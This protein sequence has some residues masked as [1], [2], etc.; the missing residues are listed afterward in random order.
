M[1]NAIRTFAFVPQQQQLPMFSL[2]T[3]N[4]NNKHAPAILFTTAKSDSR[5]DPLVDVSSSP[6]P[7]SVALDTTAET[8][9]YQ[10]A[11]QRTLGWVGAAS[12]FGAALWSVSPQAGQEFLAGYLV[13]QSLSVDNLFVF[14]VLFDYFQV[15]L[16]YQDRVLTWGIYGAVLFRAIMIAV[17]AVAL[18]QF[19][20]ILLVFAGILVYSSA[21]ILL[22]RDTDEDDEDDPSQN[23]IIKLSR[24][25]IQSVDDFDGDRFFTVQDGVRFATPLFICMVAVEIS[26]IVFAVDSIPA[27]FGVTNVSCMMV[28]NSFGS[29]LYGASP[30]GPC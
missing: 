12:I 7:F 17:G 27:V 21:R 4:N 10:Q 25:L 19:H 11:I 30:S 14:L 28:Q 23:Q 16:P 24:S 15:P 2:R 29:N 3:N 9:S 18:Q 20:G 5:T 26:D 13:E 22:V 6:P 1:L 8:Y